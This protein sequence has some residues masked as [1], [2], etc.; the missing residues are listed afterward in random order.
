MH[1][2]FGVGKVSVDAKITI[3]FEKKDDTYT[4]NITQVTLCLSNLEAR[5]ESLPKEV[6]IYIYILITL[7]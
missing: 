4:V 3:I 7:L 6:D 5:S 1:L 2:L